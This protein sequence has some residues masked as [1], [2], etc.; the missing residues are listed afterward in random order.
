MTAVI[1]IVVIVLILAG[2]VWYTPFR[3]PGHRKNTFSNVYF[4]IDGLVCG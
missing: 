3:D 4:E 1:V 2:A